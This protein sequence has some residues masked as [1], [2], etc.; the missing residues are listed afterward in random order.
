MRHVQLSIKVVYSRIFVTLLQVQQQQSLPPLY[1]SD[2][3]YSYMARAKRVLLL[4]GVKRRVI[5]IN[6]YFP[7]NV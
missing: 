7:I 5:N 3:K 2:A 6:K 1:M 4:A